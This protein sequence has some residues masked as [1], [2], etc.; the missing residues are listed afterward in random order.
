VGQGPD[1]KS[2]NGQTSDLRPTGRWINDGGTVIDLMCHDDGRLSGTI[3][4]GSDGTAYKPHHLRGTYVERPDGHSGIVG[5]VAGWPQASSVTV[6]CG[7]LGPDGT[8][9]VTS[10]FMAAGPGPALDW[11]TATGGTVFR[12][13]AGQR[14]A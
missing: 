8:S 13:F 2:E 3:R 10:L 6:W 14:S 11:D 5:T 4:F 1:S 7:E 12:R 9:L